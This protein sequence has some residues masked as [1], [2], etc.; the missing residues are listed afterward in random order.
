[1]EWKGRD[2]DTYLLRSTEPNRAEPNRTSVA[3]TTT[4]NRSEPERASSVA[5]ETR[6]GRN[7]TK[8]KKTDLAPGRVPVSPGAG[9][10]RRFRRDETFERGRLLRQIIPGK[11]GVDDYNHTKQNG[12]LDRGFE[13]R[14][15]SLLMKCSNQLS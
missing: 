1:M 15:S 7:R 9:C 6:R 12:K 13:P 2:N 14:T 3:T 8:R 4:K 10:Q 11:I 5:A